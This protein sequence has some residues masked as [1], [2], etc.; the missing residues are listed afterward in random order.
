MGLTHFD[1]ARA[2]ERAVGHIRG[3]W[4]F[5]GEALDTQTVGV[6]RIQIPAGGWSTPAHDHGCEEEIFYV[7]HGWGVSWQRGKTAE[8]GPGD[9]ILYRPRGGAHTV[10]ADEDLDLLAFGTRRYDEG[11]GF[12]R[13]GLSLLGYRGVESVPGAIDGV[14]LQFV[15]EAEVGP[16]E[17]ADEHGPRPGTIVNLDDLQADAIERPRVVR[18]RRNFGR[19]LGSVAA[20]LQHVEVAPGKESTA[21]HCHS[22]EE[23]IFV[24][25][26]GGGVLVL[27]EEETSVVPGHVVGRPAATGVAHVFRAGDQGLTYLAYGTRDPSDVCFYPRS[28]K[29]AFRGVHL[30]ARLERL[31]YWDGED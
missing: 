8:I 4:T 2:V 1:E 18:T 11:P 21:Q 10:R 28:N 22:A 24:I 12:P 16:P 30:I 19:A 25:L 7:M 20:G 15:R 5:L 6:R 27:G 26:A 31:E 3:R 9:A 17:V 29:I 23:E 13:L 14:P